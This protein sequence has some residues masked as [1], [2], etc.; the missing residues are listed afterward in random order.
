[1]GFNAWRNLSV[2]LL[3]GA[4][5]IG[6]NNGPQKNK[7]PIATK[8][9]PAGGLP[10]GVGQANTGGIPGGPVN[11]ANQFPTAKPNAAP[12]PFL[13]T[14]NPG[15]P[16][17]SQGVQQ[18]AVGTLPPRFAPDLGPPPNTSL[19]NQPPSV[20]KTNGSFAEQRGDI[21]LNTQP[22]IPPANGGG[23]TIPVPQG[24]DKR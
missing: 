8:G 23:L 2:L 1:M 11:T 21:R 15:Q 22:E 12:N 19:L 7:D 5:L 16:G 24:F 9:P 14:A 4:A 18:P 17:L 13:Q 3:A 6:C 10:V 20:Q